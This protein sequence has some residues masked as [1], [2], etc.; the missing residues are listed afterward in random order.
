[1][2]AEEYRAVRKH[3]IEVEAPQI[4]VVSAMQHHGVNLNTETARELH[5]EYFELLTAIKSEMDNYFLTRFGLSNVNYASNPQMVD[6]IYHKMKCEP[7]TKGREKTPDY[8][9][10]VKLLKS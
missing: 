3:Y 8:G 5:D 6:I 7:F 9:T 1:M 4:E 2:R 10:G